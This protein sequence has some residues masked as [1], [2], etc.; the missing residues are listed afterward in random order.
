MLKRLTQV[1]DAEKYESTPDGV[2]AIIFTAEG[3][4]RYALNNLQA[5]AAGFGSITKE[6]VFKVCDQPHPDLMQNVIRQ[7]LQSKY[8]DSCSSINIVFNEG[9]NLVDLI[10]TL[11]RVMQTMTDFKSEE[12]RLNYLKEASI[13]KMR[14]LEG[15][16]SQLQ[17][18]GFLAKLCM[19]S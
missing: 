6:N 10:N 1:I 11:T 14:T 8:Q 3:D 4:M 19:L 16:N 2:E 5:T 15:N 12:L 7:C 18:H 9:Y 13:I 17:L